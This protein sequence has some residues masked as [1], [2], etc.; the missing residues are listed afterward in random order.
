MTFGITVDR[1]PFQ[2]AS[3]YKFLETCRQKI[4]RDSNPLL[5]VV[6]SAYAAEC[7]PQDK[8]TPPFPY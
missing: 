7:F 3:I 6:E 1:A 2:N 5:K 8:K 4:A